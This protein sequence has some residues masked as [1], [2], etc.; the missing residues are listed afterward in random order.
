MNTKAPQGI[1]DRISI[2][3]AK[4]LN[5][6]SSGY[7]PYTPS[8]YATL[9]RTLQ[10][11][12]I[13]LIEGNQKISAAIKYL[14]QSTWSHA[15]VYVGMID[16]SIDDVEECGEP[17]AKL[18]EVN[19]GEGCV[20]VPLSKYE[21]YNTRICRAIGLSPGDRQSIVDFMVDNLGVQYD[22][23]NILDLVRYLLPAPPVPIRWR[24]RMLSLGSGEPTRAI[25]STLIAQAFQ[26]IQYPIL[27]EVTL[28]P[29]RTAAKSGYSRREILHIRHHSLFTPRDFDLSPYFAIVKPTVEGGFDHTKLNWEENPSS[30]VEND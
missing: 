16:G 6:E 19:L 14:T 25:C 26:S 17:E 5:R 4:R 24:R 27:P 28:A 20:A 15:A 21:T 11:G 8:D 13:L 1:L 23:R 2:W 18:I 22:L 9:C 30:E 12:D 10:P 29:G 7:Q 3:I